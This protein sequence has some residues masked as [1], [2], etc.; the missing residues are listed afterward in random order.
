MR[1]LS[2]SKKIKI[3]TIL[4]KIR[5][6]S[7]LAAVIIIAAAGIWFFIKVDKNFE[8]STWIV[9][10]EVKKLSNKTDNGALVEPVSQGIL[11]GKSKAFGLLMAIIFTFGSAIVLVLGEGKRHKPVLYYVLKTISLLLVVGFIVYV[12]MFDSMFFKVK[13]IQLYAEYNPMMAALGYIG[14]AALMIN[15]VANLVNHT[16]LGFEE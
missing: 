6:F 15:I 12:G 1:E 14:L 13:G 7:L 10:E 2:E 5:L 8:K 11:I 4:G 3:D 9:L 16:I